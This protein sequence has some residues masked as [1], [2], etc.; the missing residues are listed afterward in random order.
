M[1]RSEKIKATLLLLQIQ[2]YNIYI[3]ICVET[4]NLVTFFSYCVVE[5]EQRTTYYLPAFLPPD[6]LISM[7]GGFIT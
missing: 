6:L 4:V 7:H 3:L 1:E 2:M 5:T